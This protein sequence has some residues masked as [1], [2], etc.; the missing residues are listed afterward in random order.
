MPARS[1]AAYPQSQHAAIG[2]PSGHARAAQSGSGVSHLKEGALALQELRPLGVRKLTRPRGGGA[3]AHCDRPVS[4]LV[5]QQGEC[6][7]CQLPCSAAVYVNN[8]ICANAHT[9]CSPSSSRCKALHCLSHTFRASLPCA[10]HIWQCMEQQPIAPSGG[11]MRLLLQ[12][13]RIPGAAT[14]LGDEPSTARRSSGELRPPCPQPARLSLGSLLVVGGSG[15]G[16]PPPCS[17]HRGA[18]ATD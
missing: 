8:Y 18:R 3:G 14:R 9:H 5:G 7:C 15:A 17:I 13:E 16:S 11:P 12:L 4:I 1:C 6:R 10:L 2:N